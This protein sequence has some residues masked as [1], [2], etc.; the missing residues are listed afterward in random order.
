MESSVRGMQRLGSVK[1]SPILQQQRRCLATIK[2]LDNAASNGC[3]KYKQW[4]EEK[5]MLGAIKAFSEGLGQN[6][7]ALEYG[8][9]ATTLKDRI[10]GKVSHGCKAGKAP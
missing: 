9:P 7:A 1:W 5:T 3:G 4:A 2:I 10:S 6:R 8:V